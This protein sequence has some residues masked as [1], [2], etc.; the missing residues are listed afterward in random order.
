M[1][2]SSLKSKKQETLSTAEES[3][4]IYKTAPKKKFTDKEKHILDNLA[5]SVD[6]VKKYSKGKTKAKSINQLLNEL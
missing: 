5:H 2:R 6:F 3:A 4:A 1:K